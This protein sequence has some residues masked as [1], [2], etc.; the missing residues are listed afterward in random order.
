[1]QTWP[2]A[3]RAI[4][5]LVPMKESQCLQPS[6]VI[7]MEVGQNDVPDGQ[8]VHHTPRSRARIAPSPQYGSWAIN[9]NPP[10]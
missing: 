7:T 9:G 10:A 3:W 5:R 4:W 8:R 2:G 1:M 6:T